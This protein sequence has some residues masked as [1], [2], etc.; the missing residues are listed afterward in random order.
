VGFRGGIGRYGFLG[1]ERVGGTLFS[2]REKENTSSLDNFVY[3]R[4]LESTKIA[5]MCLLSP[6]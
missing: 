1:G 3:V 4:G 6:F 5:Q 2:A